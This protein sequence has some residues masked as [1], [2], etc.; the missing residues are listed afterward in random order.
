MMILTKM[1]FIWLM[2]IMLAVMYQPGPGPL[3][4]NESPLALWTI[5]LRTARPCQVLISAGNTATFSEGSHKGSHVRIN[6]G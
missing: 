1:L 2:K 3:N 4:C 5:Y 6:L